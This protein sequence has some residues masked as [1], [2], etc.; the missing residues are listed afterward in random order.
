ML[1]KNVYK[2]YKRGGGK[3]IKSED[4]KIINKKHKDKGGS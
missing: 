2:K 4:Y 3:K 1:N